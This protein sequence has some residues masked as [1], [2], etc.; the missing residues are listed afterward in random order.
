M[1][2]GNPGDSE[3]G[4][5]GFPDDGGGNAASPA[6]G[7]TASSPETPPASSGNPRAGSFGCDRGDS[8]LL[9]LVCSLFGKCAQPEKRSRSRALRLCPRSP[10]PPR[11]RSIA[12]SSATP[13]I[14][15][16]SPSA[17]LGKSPELTRDAIAEAEKF[18]AARD[19]PR[20]VM[21]YVKMAKDFPQSEV[22]RVRLELLLSK[23][24]SEKGALR[25]ENFDALRDPLTEA[26]KLDVGQRDG[27]SGR[28]PAQARSESF[29]R[30]AL[31]GRGAR[32]G[33]RHGGSRFALL[34]RRGG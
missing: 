18:E 14:Q 20:A 17:S 1:S 21:A 15:T 26:A 9:R 11:R 6:G 31:R 8:F 29:L 19:W 13:S 23:L 4:R 33:A 32:A 2:R 28:V 5:A 3:S 27:N 16:P 12:Q 25:D 7:D 10:P 34:K 22:G 24:Q 30:L